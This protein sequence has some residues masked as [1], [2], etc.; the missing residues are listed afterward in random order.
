MPCTSLDWI[1]HAC[2]HIFDGIQQLAH[3]I[4]LILIELFVLLIIAQKPA[5]LTLITINFQQMKINMG[6][7]MER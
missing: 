1:V 5:L 3:I 6:K 2:T 7:Y 4:V